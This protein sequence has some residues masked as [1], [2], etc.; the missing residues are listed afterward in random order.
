MFFLSYYIH[1]HQKRSMT[2]H[3]SLGVLLSWLTFTAVVGLP[4]VSFRLD[5]VQAWWCEEIVKDVVDEFL[6]Q[7]VPINL[8]LIG[9]T[10]E[11]N[12][13]NDISSLL[14]CYWYNHLLLMICSCLD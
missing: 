2:P 7:G 12:S 5:D 1:Y 6:A 14:F 13:C 8:G 4:T 11:D 9:D 10:G 3:L